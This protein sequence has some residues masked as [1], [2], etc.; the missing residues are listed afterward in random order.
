MKFRA[1]SSLAT[2]LGLV[3]AL[4][5]LAA[6]AAQLVVVLLERNRIG[7]IEVSAPT[8][9]RFA[10]IS[11]DAL[12]RNL[13][14]L[15][16]DQARVL[17]RRGG[18]IAISSDNLV[19]IRGISRNSQLEQR[20]HRALTDL[21]H[22]DIQVMA[23][24]RVIDGAEV[25]KEFF[26]GWPGGRGRN[27]PRDMDR[28]GEQN[29]REIILAAELAPGRWMSGAFLAPAPPSGD[30]GRWLLGALIAVGC[31][32]GAAIWMA[33]RLV[34]P[35]G[36]LASAAGRLG[37][38]AK[39]QTIDVRGPRE[40]RRTL[41]AFNNMSERV[42]DLLR[43]KDVMLGAL[44]HDLRT[45]LASLR[46]R[47]EGMEPESERNKAVETIEET[48]RLLESILD[49][50]RAG[51][52]GKLEDVDLVGVVDEL[53][54]DYSIQ[55]ASIERVAGVDRLPVSTN[56]DLLRR[57][58]RNL[59][60]NA[61]RHGETVALTLGS[62]DGVGSVLV[63]DDGPGIPEDQLG[64]VLE[65][66]YRVEGS[67]NRG[68]GGA[69]LGLALADTLARSLGGKL[70]LSNAQPHGLIAEVLLPIRSVDGRTEG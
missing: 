58:L 3:M 2:Q 63:R 52:A 12:N 41:S 37:S 29:V 45:P 36:D 48:T 57:L 33:A 40:I 16:G 69:G 56:L 54:E 43:E 38:S 51:Q 32:L 60:D 31:V 11:S 30:F 22:G 67:R 35:L 61:C 20:L 53:V 62:E 8:I 55:G 18:R 15:G 1:P 14:E 21:G 24:T 39:P 34:R 27:A 66:F 5:V 23:S 19:M 65:P 47:V 10:D 13:T 64:R 28:R 70:E 26:D 7:L 4:A 49:F 9:T 44:G 46:I 59:I 25:R 50:A 6:A 17:L 68:S 42:S